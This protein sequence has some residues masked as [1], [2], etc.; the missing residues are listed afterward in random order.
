[1]FTED[2]PHDGK[3][4]ITITFLKDGRI[5]KTI[6]DYGGNAP[7]DLVWAYARLRHLHCWIKLTKLSNTE[8]PAYLRMR[9]L[10]FMKGNTICGLTQSESFLLWSYLY[11]GKQTTQLA[12]PRFNLRNF[13][14]S[15]DNNEYSDEA[16]NIRTDGRLYTFFVK[17]QKPVT[18]DIGFN[19]FDRNYDNACFSQMN[20]E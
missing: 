3:E 11:K 20:R 1:M 15:P 7:A 14:W 10:S 17:G 2:D 19:F 4:E 18:I 13:L 6:T 16:N 8:L 12:T 5:Y 9:F